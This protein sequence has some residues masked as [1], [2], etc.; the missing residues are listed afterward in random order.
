MTEQTIPKGRA[1]GGVARAKALNPE[2]RALIA[3]AGALARWANHEPKGPKKKTVERVQIFECV[4]YF[5]AEDPSLKGPC[6][7]VELIRAGELVRAYS[8]PGSYN[9]AV[10]YLDALRDLGLKVSH[11]ERLVAGYN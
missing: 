3:K 2:E 10:S 8:G 11:T 9:Q 4:L 7:Q 1:R 6:H 5:S